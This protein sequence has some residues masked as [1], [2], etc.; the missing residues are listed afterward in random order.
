MEEYHPY[1]H[2]TLQNIIRK[3]CHI[4]SP[5]RYWHEVAGSNLWIL[6]VGHRTTGM[7]IWGHSYCIRDH[8]KQFFDICFCPQHE[9][10]YEDIC[11]AN[12]LAKAKHL[13]NQYYDTVVNPMSTQTAQKEG[14]V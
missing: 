13:A 8:L 4:K 3:V 6:Y 10:P 12:T 5:D 7:E 9:R 11:A 1:P 14:I 2:R